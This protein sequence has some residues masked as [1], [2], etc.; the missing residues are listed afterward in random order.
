MRGNYDVFPLIGLSLCCC[1]LRPSDWL[2]AWLLRE[3]YYIVRKYPVVIFP[4]LGSDNI[5]C[6]E[7]HTTGTVGLGRQCGWLRDRDL[8]SGRGGKAG[9]GKASVASS[10]SLMCPLLKRSPTV[11]AACPPWVCF[12]AG[13]SQACQQPRQSPH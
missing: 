7:L 10:A 4:Q 11:D 3:E 2:A 6:L 12:M 13:E 8:W 9:G 1:S 5:V